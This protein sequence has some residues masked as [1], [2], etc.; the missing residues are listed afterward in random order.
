MNQM[1]DIAY[2]HV[3]DLRPVQIGR[4]AAGEAVLSNQVA[5]MAT[6]TVC[7]PC[8]HDHA[9][10]LISHLSN[11]PE[12]GRVALLLFDDGSD[13]DALTRQ[14]ARH[15]MNH[16]GP[17][18][19]VTA[20]KNG[21][22]SQARNRL[23]DLAE[24]DWVLLID[25]DMR[26]DTDIFFQRYIKA[27]E[28]ADGPSLIAGGF[29]LRQVTPTR[30]TRLHA[31]QSA[32]SECLSAEARSED[33]GRY[34]FTSNI[35]VHKQILADIT[36]DDGF[37]GWGWEDVDWGLRVAARF[38]VRHIENTATHLGLDDTDA[39]LGK[40]GRSGANFARLAQRHPEAVRHMRLWKMAHVLQRL[41]F[42]KA[43]TRL[44]RTV[45]RTGWIPVSLR[46]LALK[47]YRAF[48]Y[49]EHLA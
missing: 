2:S 41:P 13:D 49:G 21:G 42:R 3:T 31:A 44:S 37:T 22:R 45:A 12:T 38:P 47:L 16:P 48:C 11:L 6:L 9:S 40:F 27:I 8:Y 35:L 28:N 30:Q 15:I 14:L 18:R 17:A 20:P 10:P 29:T 33:P 4:T 24:T 5:G 25:A 26:P 19:L 43:L 23:V 1:A 32:R 39:L 7:V 46:L 34:V 36:F